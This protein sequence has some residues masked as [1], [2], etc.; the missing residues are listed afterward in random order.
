MKIKS[1]Y[2]NDNSKINITLIAILKKKKNI[3]SNI[4]L[5]DIGGYNGHG[6]IVTKL[7]F[8]LT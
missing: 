8:C 4:I 6:P 2:R 7:S 3:S 1:A 5:S